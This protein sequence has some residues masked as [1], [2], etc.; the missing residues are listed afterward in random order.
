MQLVESLFPLPFLH[1]IFKFHDFELTDAKN[2]VARRDLV[3]EVLA[4]LSDTKGQFGVHGVEHVFEVN[5]HALGSLGAQVDLGGGIVDGAGLGGKHE[6]KDAGR[7][8]RIALG[9]LKLQL[10]DFFIHLLDGELSHVLH[11]VFFEQVVGAVALVGFEVFHER[12]GEA[13]AG[14]AGGLPDTRVHENGAIKA[15]HVF[16]LGDKMLPPELLDVVFEQ[17]AVRAVIPGTGETPVNVGALKNKTA[18]LGE[19][20][21][22]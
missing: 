10:N 14:V 1:K 3:A 11:A 12:I 16:A 9:A 19:R 21:D 22:R 4:N 18:P 2:E 6:V 17:D 7:R 13:G 8:Q 15:V 5:E 20:N